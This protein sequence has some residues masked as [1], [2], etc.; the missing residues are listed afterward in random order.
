MHEQKR[1]VV[2]AFD[3]ASNTY[4]APALRFFDAHA[5]SLVREARI[6]EGARVLDVATGTGKVATEAARAVGPQGSVLG[7]DLSEGMLARARPKAG[8]L[9][10]EF[11]QMDA[12]SLEL[13]DATFDFVLCGFG[14][15]FLPD[16]VR[17][18]GEMRRVLRPG[19]RLVFSTWTKQT[20]EPLGERTLACLE[21][22]DI[23]RPPPPAEPWMECKEPA[24]L[25]T[26]LERGGFQNGQVIPQRAGYFIQPEEWWTFMWGT[27]MRRRLSLL[28]P[29]GLERFKT[30]ILD[31]MRN[32]Q[33][34]RGIWLEASALIGTGLRAHA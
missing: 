27:S 18:L 22:Y 11:R 30:E 31:V 28:S 29:E 14:I 19:G 32:L 25:L 2:A 17:G 23:P 13:D 6:H 33:E 34:E 4:D 21:R 1:R 8:A 5:R 24:H 20:F 12:E 26:A 9:P 3:L 16:M 7:V 15:F 10:V